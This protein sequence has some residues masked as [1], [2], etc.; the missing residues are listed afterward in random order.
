VERARRRRPPGGQR[1]DDP[2]R[3]PGRP[4]RARFDFD[5]QNAAGVARWRGRTPEETLDHLREVLTRTTTPPAPL[6]SRIVE[7]VVHGEDVRRPLGIR[8]D[9]PVDAVEEALRLQVRTPASFG[10]ARELVAGLRLVADEGATVGDGPEVRGPL[11]SLLLAAAGRRV[12]LDELS[13]PGVATL[14]SR[15]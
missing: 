13:G 10:G 3:L 11:V 9:Y 1:P 2:H 8:R 15:S 12:A 4:A 14:V 7:E 5:R 6:A